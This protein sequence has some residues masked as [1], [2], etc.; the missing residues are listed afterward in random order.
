MIKLYDYIQLYVYICNQR[1]LNEKLPSC[2][3][4]KLR[5]KSREKNRVEQRRVEERRDEKE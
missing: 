5:E 4:L 3:D 2:T 1:K